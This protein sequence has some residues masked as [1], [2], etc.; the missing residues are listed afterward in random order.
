MR[1]ATR[2]LVIAALAM[3]PS[4]AVAQGSVSARAAALYESYS[5]DA[6]IAFSKVAELTVPVGVDIR[7]GRLGTLAL[8]TGFAT[9]NLTSALDPA[10]LPDQTVS[11]PL[12]TEVRLSRDLVPGKLVLILNGAVPT[13]TKTVEQRQLAVLGALS[14]DVIGFA[15]PSLGSGGNLGGGFVGAV[16]LGKFAVGFGAT[17]KMPLSYTPVVGQARSLQPGAEIRIRGGLEG[18]L[19]RKT[20]LRFAGIFARSSRDKVSG[21]LRNGIGARVISY[22][23]IN[24]G[25]GPVSITLYGFDVYRGGPQ[26]EPTAVGAA[27]L[28][29]GNLLSAGGRID[30]NLT[31]RTTV[32]PRVEYR[33]SA[34]APDTATTQLERLGQSLRFGLDIRQTFTRTFAVGLQ[35]GGVTGNVVQAGADIGFS[36]LRAALQFEYTP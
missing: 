15:A 31:P 18:A 10:D 17:Y 4:R 2:H 35:A 16:P 28:P 34:A 23:S 36:G 11:G 32:S 13:G 12:D 30:Y 29:K 8:S 33:I 19:A 9:V 27:V 14:S 26:I 21:D 25:V 1:R 3:L 24:Q 5:F 7:L 6:G 20:Y 22:V